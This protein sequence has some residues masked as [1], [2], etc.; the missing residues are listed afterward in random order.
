MKE[1]AFAIAIELLWRVDQDVELHGG[2][3][4]VDVRDRIIAFEESLVRIH[5]EYQIE[6]AFPILRAS[7]TGAE[8][9]RFNDPDSLEGREK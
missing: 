8:Y 1:W 9:D 4:T 7:R 6:V 3:G 2:E 5:D